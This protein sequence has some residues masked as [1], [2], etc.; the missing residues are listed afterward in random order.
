MKLLCRLWFWGIC[1][2]L[3]LVV[4]IWVAYRLNWPGTGF[5]GK[6]VWDW[7]SL[8]VIPVTLA[9]VALFFNQMNT[10]AERQIAKERYEQDK[11]AADKRY[12]QDKEI[13]LDK[14][15]EELFQAYLDRMSELLLEK[16]LRA[17]RINEEVRNV[18]KVRT[19]SILK[20]LDAM[21][22]GLVFAFLRESGL[23]G[24]DMPIVDLTGVDFTGVNWSQADMGGVNLSR[25]NFSDANLSGATF[26]RTTLTAAWF[27]NTN[28]HKTVFRGAKLQQAVFED[29][30]VSEAD[31]GAD[32]FPA[33]GSTDIDETDL[34]GASF[35]RA[36]FS[37]THFK[38]T[39]LKTTEI[40]RSKLTPIQ[41]TRA[42]W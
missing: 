2:G 24:K 37:G 20:Q 31:F 32:I 1:V 28:L 29:V 22:V 42:R 23:M 10:R 35:I 18:A 39:N 38:R 41:I 30:D 25:A 11:E 36:N 5:Q 16:G 3:A 33:Y 13:A 15:R 9:L 17:S 26:R 6:T 14:Q 27:R 4:L 34:G 7:L 12:K 21:R 8:F 40:D 19:I